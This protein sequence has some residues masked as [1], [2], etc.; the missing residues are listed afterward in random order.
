M[1]SE[2]PCSDSVDQIPLS[3]I[4]PRI[5][6]LAMELGAT[7][8]TS[9]AIFTP[10]G[11][12]AYGDAHSTRLTPTPIALTAS[13]DNAIKKTNKNQAEDSDPLERKDDTS[14]PAAERIN[15]KYQSMRIPRY[16]VT[17]SSD[18]AGYPKGS[19]IDGDTVISSGITKKDFHKR[20]WTL[21]YIIHKTNP[22]DN[23]CGWIPL[24]AVKKTNGVIKL[25]HKKGICKT[26]AK[27]IRN[28]Y[29]FGTN[30]NGPDGKHDDGTFFTHIKD[31]CEVEP[32][33]LNFDNATGR[34]YNFVPPFDIVANGVHRRYDTKNKAR[35]MARMKVRIP[36]G[37][38]VVIDSIW[39]FLKKD[40][41]YGKMY[42]GPINTDDQG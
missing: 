27:R 30:F 26:Q 9:L 37:S 5:K 36:R 29:S 25:R 41:L 16:I 24:K 33:P 18:R 13:T 28:R 11:D 17:F 22:S 20:G 2:S 8:L 19:A 40:C 3:Q 6:H 4:A 38:K 15:P 1:G 32:W 14:L 35:S 34:P 39:P 23:E 42:G 7:M 10:G 12:Q 31:E 21:A